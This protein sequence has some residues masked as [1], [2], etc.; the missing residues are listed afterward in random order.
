[1]KTTSLTTIWTWLTNIPGGITAYLRYI[2]VKTDVKAALEKWDDIDGFNASTET[3]LNY[4]GEYAVCLVEYTSWT[5]TKIDDQIAALIRNVL[6]NHRNIAA[7]IINWIRSGHNPGMQELTAM[8]ADIC[9]AAEGSTSG[10]TPSGSTPMDILFI[11]TALYRL[12]MQL[13]QL[14]NENTTEPPVIPEPVLPEVERQPIRNLIR[15][16]FGKPLA[17]A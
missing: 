4:L 17:I 1:M 6:I 10:S 8:T 12:L 15:K 13:I 11:I 9:Y 16:L 3:L 14:R 2:R 5:T 7:T